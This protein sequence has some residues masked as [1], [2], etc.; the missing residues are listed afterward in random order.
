MHIQ[1]ILHCLQLWQVCYWRLQSSSKMS[2]AFT[3]SP[4]PR[5]G[6][7]RDSYRIGLCF[8]LRV[9]VWHQFRSNYEASAMLGL[10][11]LACHS[12]A[13]F[14][15]G[16]WEYSERVCVFFFSVGVH[17]CCCFFFVRGGLL[18]DNFH[19][20]VWFEWGIVVELV[21][22]SCLFVGL[23]ISSC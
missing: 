23:A 4:L 6:V 15:W 18:V 16:L 20:I 8:M 21:R 7:S 12:V 19:P 5:R 13:V 10:L 3:L 14:F 1:M 2:K 17:D 22:V 9:S 11:K